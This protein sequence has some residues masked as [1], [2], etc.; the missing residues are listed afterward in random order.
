MGGD[1]FALV[2]SHEDTLAFNGSGNAP[3][4]W[5]RGDPPLGAATATVPGAVAALADLHARYGRINWADLIEPAVLLAQEGIR[6]SET[7]RSALAR[8]AATL[9]QTARDWS[10]RNWHTSPTTRVRQPELATVLESIAVEGPAAFYEGWIGSQLVMSARQGGAWLGEAD[11]TQHATEVTTPVS[12]DVG[13]WTVLAQPPVSQAALIPF[14]LDALQRADGEDAPREH[15]LIEA[16]EEG[17]AWRP[18]LYDRCGIDKLPWGWTPPGRPA[19]RLGGARGT[20]HT[21]SVSTT[22][23]DGMV[24]SM[25]VSVFHEFGSGYFV[26]R[27]GLFLN[28]RMLGFESTA[29]RRATRPVHTLSPVIVRNSNGCVGAATP[30][31][32]AQVQV[33]SQVLDQVMYAQDPWEVA[34]S[35]PRWRL[36]HQRLVLEEEFDSHVRGQL[37]A[38]G[39]DIL[40]V[41]LGDHS[42]GAV[43]LAG[44]TRTSPDAQ[45]VCF[46][47]ADGRRGSDA[48]QT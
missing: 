21:T 29:S 47:L 1:A 46:S 43:T 38:L 39:H 20:A 26:P 23:S 36:D 14:A 22:D 13:G 35:R 44:W 16:L 4:E 27:L 15:L 12:L 40:S 41:P 37:A 9:D 5:L 6:V 45:R 18:H 33:L 8:R 30:G 19:R 34:I 48:R 32:D 10:V 25:L 28:D 24:V 31:A 17:F 3:H 42:M 2:S 11:L 7:L